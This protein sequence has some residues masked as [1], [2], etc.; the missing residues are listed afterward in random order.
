MNH[1]PTEAEVSALI[2]ANPS[3]M[4]AEAIADVFGFT[5]QRAFQIIDRAVVKVR[6]RLAARRIYSA[7]DVMA[8]SYGSP[9]WRDMG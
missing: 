4:T 3:G 1:E 7:G 5:R 8:E 6:A 2:A 9:T